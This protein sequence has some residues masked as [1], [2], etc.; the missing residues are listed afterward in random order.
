MIQV[1][2]FSESINIACMIQNIE[3]FD[4]QLR[5]EET[6]ECSG[7]DDW[8]NDMEFVDN[9]TKE[10]ERNFVIKERWRRRS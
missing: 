4:D 3:D 7:L 9:R 8:K 2:P 6:R 5:L 1:I 10:E